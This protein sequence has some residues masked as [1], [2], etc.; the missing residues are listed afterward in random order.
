LPQLRSERG[1]SIATP[2]GLR[3]AGVGRIDAPQMPNGRLK[4]GPGK[5]APE[6]ARHQRRRI[7]SAMVE[8]VAEL[9]Y[10]A[11]TVRGLA[12]RASVSTRTFYQHYASKDDC[13]WAVHQLIVRRLLRSIGAAQAGVAD[14]SERLQR[15]IQATTREWSH[16]PKA[17]R[18]MLIEAYMAGLGGATRARKSMRLIGASFA[19]ERAQGLTERH[20][21]P[22]LA[23]GVIA[24][25]AG[26]AR[27]RLLKEDGDALVDLGDELA[28]WAISLQDPAAAELNDLELDLGSRIAGLS[29]PVP[30]SRG[31]EDGAR[32]LQGDRALL[33]SAVTKLSS[34]E[35]YESVTPEKIYT[36]AGVSRR[37]FFLDFT[38]VEDA[39]VEAMD[40][41][42]RQAI[43]ALRHAADGDMLPAGSVYEIVAALCVLTTESSAFARLCVGDVAGSGLSMMHRQEQLRAEL[44]ALIAEY[45]PPT[46]PSDTLF[47]EASVA[48]SFAL[49][50]KELGIARVARAPLV[51]RTLT[52]LVLVP[53]KFH[54]PI[55]DRDLDHES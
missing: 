51:A 35:E 24:G 42:A 33:L 36:A 52:S 30:S 16:N 44:A 28:R 48:A 20:A 46:Y 25:V 23:E 26:V 43:A 47:L 39:F 2:M 53:L 11:V 50:Q 40:W 21:S 18:L 29:S 1:A 15:S 8:A 32:A 38:S 10:D 12:R 17:A 55:S 45:L 13:F 22:P 3:P 37:R 5:S 19:G 7:H 6:V 41:H 31:G 54:K 49:L 14:A 4:P 34:V 9:G 27:S